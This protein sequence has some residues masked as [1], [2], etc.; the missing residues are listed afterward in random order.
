MRIVEIYTLFCVFSKYIFCC[1]AFVSLCVS[2]VSFFFQSDNKR[3]AVLET[4]NYTN[5]SLASVAY[6]INTLAYNMLQLLDLQTMQLAEMESQIN[7]IHET[8]MIHK[9]KIARR[10]IGILT[11]NKNTTRQHK[12]LAP[13]TQERPIKYIRKPVDYSLLDDIGHGVKTTS[14]TPRSKRPLAP[15][16]QNPLNGSSAGPPPTTKPPTPPQPVRAG[17]SLT[18]S[19]KEYRAP[20]LP[21]A[22]PQVPCNYA[23]NY[24]MG[25]PRRGSGYS[26]LPMVSAP[27]PPQLLPPQIGMVHPMTH[28]HHAS[29]LGP[30]SPIPPP[31]PPDG[32]KLTGKMFVMLK[33]CKSNFYMYF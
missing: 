3:E 18:R 21:I 24:P 28:S 6:Q 5:Q 13:S 11:T 16:H 17:G 32:E 15:V 31:P 7:H 9:E 4:K 1:T 20:Q 26:T 12:I 23:P 2:F 30:S 29:T 22:P 8:V 14:N 27:Q 10:E 19:A 25:H 33:I